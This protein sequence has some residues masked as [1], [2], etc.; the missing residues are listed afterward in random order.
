MRRH[1]ARGGEV[2]EVDAGGWQTKEARQARDAA[3]AAGNIPLLTKEVRVVERMYEATMAHPDCRT[4]FEPGTFTPELVI[5]W[6]DEP[7]GLMCRAMIDAVPHYGVHMTMVD[8]KTKAG[9]AD[10]ASVSTSM[11]KYSYHQQLAHY[12][13]GCRAIG[14][15]DTITPVLVVCGKEPPHVPLCRPVDAEAIEVGEI[16]NRKALDLYAECTASGVWPG[17]DDPG[18]ERIPLTLPGWKR[19]AFRA[20]QG[21]GVYEVDETELF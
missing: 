4:L 2:V 20:A 18:G 10:P 8:L 9:H 6:R 12:A 11:A 21:A 16:C 14:L 17:Y 3:Y 15:A 19:Y 5:V 13:A 7:T 1:A